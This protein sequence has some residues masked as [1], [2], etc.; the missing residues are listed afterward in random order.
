MDDTVASDLAWK[1]S[2]GLDAVL[3]VGGS[4]SGAGV[5]PLFRA[6]YAVACQVLILVV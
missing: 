3:W 4:T 5:I 1:R 2:V 6:E